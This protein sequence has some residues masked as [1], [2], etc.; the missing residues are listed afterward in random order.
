MFIKKMISVPL[1]VL[2]AS[3]AFAQPQ[4][5]LE[6]ADAALSTAQSSLQQ[7]YDGGSI[8]FKASEHE[9]AFVKAMM[10]MQTAATAI[11][12]AKK[13]DASSAKIDGILE[14]ARFVQKI[15]AAYLGNKEFHGYVLKR[16]QFAVQIDAAGVY[17]QIAR[18]L[19]F[20]GGVAVG[21][22]LRVNPG[23]QIVT[24][25]NS[26]KTEFYGLLVEAARLN[27][28]DSRI[29]SLAKWGNETDVI[30]PGQTFGEEIISTR[31][32]WDLNLAN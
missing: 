11:A 28:A 5:D 4:S 1:L 16:G 14:E 2:V 3:Q 15:L 13:S 12:N 29:K 25:F 23:E 22:Q 7:L 32:L 6:K 27:P 17:Q 30:Y 19:P 31:Q 24:Q 10:Q 18:R 26:L 21:G 20:L 9:T 8:S